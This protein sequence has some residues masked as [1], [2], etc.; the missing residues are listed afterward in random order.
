MDR[1]LA[2]WRGQFDAGF[3]IQK[4]DERLPER[5]SR[6]T[7]K[8]YPRINNGGIMEIE[9]SLLLYTKSPRC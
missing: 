3:F 2:G 1:R 7:Q 4:T 8:G 5:S 6:E 9:G